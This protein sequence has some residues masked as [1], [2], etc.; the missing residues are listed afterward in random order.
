MSLPTA[1]PSYRWRWLVIGV[2]IL[3]SALNYLDRQILA[4]LAPVLKQDLSLSDSQYGWLL[5]AFAA[6]YAVSAPWAGWL[7]DRL[8]LTRG[9][10]SGRWP[11]WPPD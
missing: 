10:D 6:C 5:S 1:T 8:G 4:Q 11:E 7:L 2:F 9:W 3:S